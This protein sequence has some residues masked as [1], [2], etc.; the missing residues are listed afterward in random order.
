MKDIFDSDTEYTEERFTHFVQY[1]TLFQCFP[2]S[3]PE[4]ATGTKAVLKIFQLGSFFF[5]IKLQVL[6]FK[7]TK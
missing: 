5:K 7:F 1:R 3:W 4:A 2:K 6:G